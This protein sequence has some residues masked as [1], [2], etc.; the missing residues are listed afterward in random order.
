MRF[1]LICMW[2]ARRLNCADDVGRKKTFAYLVARPAAGL[3][4]SHLDPFA[5]HHPPASPAP[6]SYSGAV[7]ILNAQ[8]V[9][10]PD[11]L[12]LAIQLSR[13][14]DLISVEIYSVGLASVLE[15]KQE[16][17]AAG[18]NQIPL[19]PQWKTLANGVYFARVKA[20]RGGEEAPSRVLKLMKLR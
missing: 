1:S 5:V 19:P 10:N 12:T 16:R 13:P 20:Q 6:V 3:C 7:R 11:P 8:A 18:Y 9:P 14:A 4:P 17:C 15:T 2:R